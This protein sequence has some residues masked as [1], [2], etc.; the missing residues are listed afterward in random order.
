VYNNL[1]WVKDGVEALDFLYRPEP[2]RTRPQ[3]DI[4]CSLNLPKKKTAARCSRRS[5]RRAA[6]GAFRW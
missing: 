5:R 6:Y 3:A 4:I 1:H 2:T